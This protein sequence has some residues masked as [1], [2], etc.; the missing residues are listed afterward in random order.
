MWQVDCSSGS[1]SQ[2]ILIMSFD[3]VWQ[4]NEDRSGR[5]LLAV[6]LATLK[7]RDVNGDG[8]ITADD[9]MPLSDRP[10]LLS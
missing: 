10:T 2:Q 5:P 6:S 8:E 9:R 1:Q 3:G 7:L 4:Q